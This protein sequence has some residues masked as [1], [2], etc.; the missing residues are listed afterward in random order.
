MR[1]DVVIVVVLA[2]LALLETLGRDLPGIAFGFAMPHVL[3]PLL[4]SVRHRARS[5]RRPACTGMPVGTLHTSAP[6]LA[7][8]VRAV[9]MSPGREAAAGLLLLVV[10]DVSSAATGELRDASAAHLPLLTSG[11]QRRSSRRPSRW[12]RVGSSTSPSWSDTST[13]RRRTQAA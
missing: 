4:H 12:R 3:R 9:S 8:S 10:V 5:E 11:E 7:L 2:S 13:R 6:E 1:T